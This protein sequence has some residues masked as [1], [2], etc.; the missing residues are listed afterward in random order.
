[1]GQLGIAHKD[2]SK[3]KKQHQPKTSSDVNLAQ[4]QCFFLQTVPRIPVMTSL[5]YQRNNF[6]QTRENY[7]NIEN[8][9]NLPFQA[10]GL[11]QTFRGYLE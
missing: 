1:M 9:V 11:K 7:I 10:K 3:P 4:Q 2:N 6:G 5:K 8:K